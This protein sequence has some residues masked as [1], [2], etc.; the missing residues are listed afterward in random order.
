MGTTPSRFIRHDLM[1]TDVPAGVRFYSA[2]FGWTTTEIKFMG[3]TIV[4]LLSGDRVQGAIIPFDKSL[5]FPS[6]WVPYIYV[7][8]V[9]D[10]CKRVGELAGQVCMGASQIPPGTFALVND[11][12]KA[13]F[14]PFTPITGAPAEPP[15][16]P[17]IGMFCWD[18]LLTTDVDA[19]KQFYASLFG[20]GSNEMEMGPAGS[21]TLFTHDASP[22]AGC[23]KIPDGAPQQ[24]RWV[25]YVVAEDADATAARTQELGGTVAVPPQ[26]I[27]DVGRFA[28]LSDP[29]G[30]LFGILRR[31]G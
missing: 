3:S 21:Y 29:T 24:S 11:P 28:V 13:M 22:V 4:R 18:E 7:A 16:P 8:S 5:G 10:C 25:S 31:K 6:H 20:W 2:L 1:C 17:G 23:M 27:P 26:D 15:P 19:A 14:S 9:D 30:G 12:Q